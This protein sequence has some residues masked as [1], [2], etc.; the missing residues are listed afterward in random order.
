MPITLNREQSDAIYSQLRTDITGLNDIELN[1]R[2]G[3]SDAGHLVRAHV[4]DPIEEREHAAQLLLAQP[5]HSTALA[6]LAS[7]RTRPRPGEVTRKASPW[8]STVSESSQE[9]NSGSREGTPGRA[10]TELR[11][12]K[13]YACS[14]RTCKRHATLRPMGGD[15]RRSDQPQVFFQH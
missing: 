5:T 10:H 7:P 3:D 8:G 9:P 15:G 12:G 13:S 6:H 2:A 4:L 11:A 14:W 1:L